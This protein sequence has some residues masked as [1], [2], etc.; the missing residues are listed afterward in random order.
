MTDMKQK[1]VMVGTALEGRGGMSSVVASYQQNGF[2]D[3]AQVHY[4]EAHREVPVRRKVLLALSGLSRLARLL[5]S[6]RVSLVHIHVASGISFWRKSLYASLAR[7]FGRPVILHIHGGSFLEFFYQCPAPARWLIRWQLEGAARVIVLSPT[8]EETVR[9][10]SPRLHF[11]V[12]PNP[13]ALPKDAAVDSSR[14]AALNFLFLGR[15][16]QA[17]G[18]FEAVRAFAQIS[19]DYPHARLIL[20]GDG[21]QAVVENLATELGINEKVVYAGWVSGEAKNRVLAS[22]HAFILP[23]HI[24]GLPVSMLEAMAYGVPVVVSR[25]GSVPEVLEHGVNG[26]MIEAGNVESLRTAMAALAASQEMR[27]FLGK[28]GR[29]LVAAQFAADR[30]CLRL[31]LIYAEVSRETQA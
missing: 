12:L 9:Q 30:V 27:S 22:A 1:I 13:V 18:V 4:V 15:L 10:I 23:S 11:E 5:V 25:V 24:E 6:G 31:E 20:A 26:L 7:L 28:A 2:L 19:G 21:D 3:R 16:E 29:S 14:G 17:K 8:W